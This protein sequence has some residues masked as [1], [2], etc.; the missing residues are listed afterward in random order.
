[1]ALEVL[2]G[3]G[4]MRGQIVH[5]V[6][7]AV[8]LSGWL[9]VPCAALKIAPDRVKVEAEAR[10]IEQM[11]AA[12]D[13]DGLVRMLSEGEFPSKEATAKHLSE[14]GD[15]RAL[16][17]L[18]RLNSVHGGW[19]FEW[20]SIEEDR[21]GAFAVAIC[22]IQNREQSEKAQIEA[23]LDLV[24]G[25]G[26]AVPES[27]EP[28]K[29][30]MNGVLRETPL[31]LDRNQWVGECVAAELDRFDD[32]AIAPRLRRSENQGISPYAVW[33]EVRDMGVEAGIARCVQIARDEGD[34][35]RYGAL[36][37]LG[38]FGPDSVGALDQLAQEGHGEAIVVLSRWK[39]DPEVFEL[40]C[41]HATST[42]NYW[43]RSKAVDAVSYVSDPSFEVR[44]LEALVEALYDPSDTIR[45]RAATA[46]LNRAYPHN[47]PDFDQVEDS[48]LIA[49]RHPDPEVSSRIRKG[50]ERLGCERLHEAVPDPP[51]IRTDLDARSPLPTTAQQRLKAKVDP[52]E[53]EAANALRFGPA[54]KAIT[55]YEELLELK[56]GFEPY[57]KALKT[58]KAYADAAAQTTESWPPD[59]SYIAFKGRYSYVLACTHYDAAHLKDIF[60]L[61]ADLSEVAGGWTRRPTNNPAALDLNLKY[62]RLFEHVIEHYPPNDCLAIR[63]RV[64][65]AELKH[66]LSGDY[67]AY[68]LSRIGL[69]TIPVEQ[70]VS[71]TD[72]SSN[73]PLAEYGGKTRAQFFVAT[74]RDQFRDSIINA[75]KYDKR[76]HYLLDVIADAC[77]QTDPTIAEMARA[78]KIE[79]SE[80]ERFER[81]KMRERFPRRKNASD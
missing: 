56:P 55:L 68:L 71:S 70:V 6:L 81:E 12:R 42:R 41:R 76:W 49:L 28:P 33:R 36:H 69:F 77:A 24:D 79:V 58:A 30:R 37:C 50:M 14:I 10:R 1:M 32:P 15:D 72:Q 11:A 61:V 5:S 59:A 17:E 18:R 52:L 4:T 9:C 13:I 38:R 74:C 8:W 45:R 26:P 46:L 65:S 53:K 27:L 16:P 2:V 29:F 22:K 62:L 19:V 64:E 54:E 78:A 20:G 44:S 43:A 39:E 48:L 80:R 40:L 23:L 21:S 7:A 66:A 3:R 63:A 67:N 35:Q 25:K 51:S 75:C 73:V 60:G 57:E 31:R 47:K 34:A